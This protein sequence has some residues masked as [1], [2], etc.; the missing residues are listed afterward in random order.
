MTGAGVKF[1]RLAG[2]GED[3]DQDIGAEV[4]QRFGV[5]GGAV[6]PV[7]R[8]GDDEGQPAVEASFLSRLLLRRLRAQLGRIGAGDRVLGALAGRGG[9]PDQR[10]AASAAQVLER[11]EAPR[12]ATSVS[13]GAETR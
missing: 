11:A 3:G 8:G 4:A 9:A 5:E 12:P 2:G 6:E 10:E 7:Q 1:Q 13:G